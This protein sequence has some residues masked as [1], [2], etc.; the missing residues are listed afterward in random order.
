MTR[1]RKIK[2]KM[3]DWPYDPAREEQV[4]TGSVTVEMGQILVADIAIVRSTK[5]LMIVEADLHSKYVAVGW[6]GGSPEGGVSVG[7]VKGEYTL[8]ADP[9]TVVG[10]VITLPAHT[11]GWDVEAFASRYTVRIIAW[12]PPR[13]LRPISPK[14]RRR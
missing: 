12:K 1:N 2:M 11:R 3:A 4:M 6:Y 13:R 7:L 9:G 8:K 14:A 5:D 10:T